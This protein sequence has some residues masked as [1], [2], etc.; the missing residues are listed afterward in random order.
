[1]LRPLLPVTAGQSFAVKRKAQEAFAVPGCDHCG[2]PCSGFTL[3]P[4]MLWICTVVDHA[5]D[6]HRGQP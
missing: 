3:W 5:L 2:R 4:A 1:M 6:L